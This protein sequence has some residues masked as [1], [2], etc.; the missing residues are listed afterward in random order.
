[1]RTIIFLS[2]LLFP[3][4]VLSGQAADSRPFLALDHTILAV[5]RLDQAQKQL[6]TFRFRFKPGRLHSNNLL[7][8]H[9]KFRD[10]TSIEPMT[11]VGPPLDSSAQEYAQLMA[12]EP[13]PVYVAI[14]TT[15][16]DSVG[17]A[18]GM[19]NLT[20]RR[21][22]IGTGRFL[23]FPSHSDAAAVFFGSGWPH[24]RDPDSLLAHTNGATGLEEAWV[25]AGPQLETMLSLL[26][27]FAGE[28]VTL[29]D[30]RE[31]S[32]WALGRGALVL[33]PPRAAGHRLRPVGVILHGQAGHRVP[34][35]LAFPGFWI[36]VTN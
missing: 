21:T 3:G 18:A 31:G 12:S 27:A 10:G 15:N 2:S 4:A 20:S 19:A 7:N 29:P 8:S 22:R 5:P 26:G 6:A 17:M 35:T 9:I 11:V 25:E 28:R 14:L 16:L 30:G 1:M 13:G 36:G 34:P 24:P 33:V 23:S 32:R